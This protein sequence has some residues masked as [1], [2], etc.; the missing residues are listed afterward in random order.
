MEKKETEEPLMSLRGNATPQEEL[1][2]LWNENKELKI[3]IQNLK[4]EIGT[5]NSELDEFKY[6]MKSTQIGAIL[7][8]HKGHKKQIESLNLKLKEIKKEN[9]TF[10]EKIIKLQKPC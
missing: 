6:E 5:L 9:S 7:L 3:E 10:L 4:I 8:K 2:W 1:L